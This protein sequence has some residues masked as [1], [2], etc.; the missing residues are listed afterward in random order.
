MSTKNSKPFT[1][2]RAARCPQIRFPRTQCNPTGEITTYYCHICDETFIDT[3]HS[4]C[5]PQISSYYRRFYKF[6]ICWACDDFTALE[7]G[8]RCANAKCRALWDG[9]ELEIWAEWV[10]GIRKG[11]RFVEVDVEAEREIME[12]EKR[13]MTEMLGKRGRRVKACLDV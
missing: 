3:I 8:D 1:T 11:G 6:Y 13:E 9:S 12:R 10:E 7:V 2:T 4:K 5:G